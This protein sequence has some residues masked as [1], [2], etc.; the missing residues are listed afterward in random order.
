[1]NAPILE[2]GR[3]YWIRLCSG[4]LRQWIY[5][6]ATAGQAWWQDAESG[7][8]FAESSILYAWEFCEESAEPDEAEVSGSSAGEAQAGC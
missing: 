8:G 2:V 6:G 5:Q 3:S 4:E 1:M 7:L